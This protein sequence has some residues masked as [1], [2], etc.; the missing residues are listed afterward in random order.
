M[1]IHTKETSKIVKQTT[2]SI[3]SITCDCCNNKVPL[4]EN[5]LFNVI[6][7]H[8]CRGLYNYDDYDCCS[9]DCAF[10]L[11]KQKKEKYANDIESIEITDE[12]YKL[13]EEY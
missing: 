2:N 5:N 1:A 9:L 6:K 13:G 8:I 11:I 12:Q 4:N 3:T 10:K 7:I